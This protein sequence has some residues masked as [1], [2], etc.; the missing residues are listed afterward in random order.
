MQRYFIKSDQLVDGHA[1]I[2]GDDVHHIRDVMRGSVGDR[3]ILCTCDKESY[4]AEIIDLSRMEIKAKVVERKAENVEL[5]VFVTISQG[6]TK[7]DKF[8]LVLQKATECGASEFV[9]VA[10]KRSVAKIDEKKADKKVLRWQKIALEAARQSHRQAVPSVKMPVD[11]QGL[12]AMADEYDMCLFAYEIGGQTSEVRDRN[13][14]AKAIR[15]FEPEMRILVLIG[16]E[17]GIDQVEVDL[18]I[19]AGFIAVGLGPRILRTETAPIYIMSAIS[20]A[21]EIEGFDD[22]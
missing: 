5:P 16:P 9:P 14:L 22:E 6:I 18:L 2:T 1:I 13:A 10:M 17:G 20:Y 8:E 19:E 4:L 3:V 15:K 7:G 21:L 11:I 12:V